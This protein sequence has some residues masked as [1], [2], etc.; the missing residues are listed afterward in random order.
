MGL[1]VKHFI[2][3]SRND[4]TVSGGIVLFITALHLLLN[5]QSPCCLSEADS[6]PIP[7]FLR[8][9]ASPLVF[10]TTGETLDEDLA[11]KAVFVNGFW[12]K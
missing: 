12:P 5:W 9:H 7:V 6:K 2:D 1:Q 3:A 8:T 10:P 4:L 11:Q